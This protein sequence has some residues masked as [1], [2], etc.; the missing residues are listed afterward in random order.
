MR[1]YSIQIILKGKII[2]FL[3]KYNVSK[4]TIVNK[5][6]ELGVQF[7]GSANGNGV[8]SGQKISK[9]FVSHVEESMAGHMGVNGVYYKLGKGNTKGGMM[10]LGER[11]EQ[12]ESLF[13]FQVLL[14][15]C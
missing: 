13:L 3:G 12:R 15:L 1:H 10:G 6:Q 14:K 9:F 4:L 5:V 11:W 8:V 7:S 2:N